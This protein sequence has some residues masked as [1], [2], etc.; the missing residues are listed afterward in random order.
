MQPSLPALTPS[1]CPSN[2]H[3]NL[4]WL[5]VIPFLDSLL[6]EDDRE[7]CGARSAWLRRSGNESD[8]ITGGMWSH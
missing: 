1:T 8:L 5:H 3:M 7:V 4:V 6:T 2:H